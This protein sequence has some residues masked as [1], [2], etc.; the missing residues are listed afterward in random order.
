[1]WHPPIA[2]TP[3]E[4]KIAAR[5]RKTRKFFVCLRARRPELLD[6]DFQHMLAKSESPE[7]R[8]KTPVDVGLLA[9]AV[10]LQADCH[11]GDRDAGERTVMDTRWQRV[12]DCLG[13]EQPPFRQGTLCNLR[14]RLMA[15]N[16]DKTLLDRTVAWAE[17]TGG[18][19]ARQRRAALDSTP[20][21]GAG[22]VE[23]TLHVLGHALRKAVGLVGQAR[24]LATDMLLAEAGLTLVGHSSLKAALALDWGESGAKEKALRLVL[25]EVDRWK[26]WLEQHQSLSAPASPL[27]DVMDTIVQSVEQDTEPDPTGSPG[28]RRLRQHVAPDRRLSIEDQDRR[29]GRKSSATMFNGFKEPCV[30]ALDSKGT[31]EVVVCPANEPE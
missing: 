30:L 6:V 11:V 14:M 26:R 13:A 10:L 7:P 15:H 27:E 1:M 5:T 2:L 22:R 28:G 23:D 17:Q 31:R 12:R 20:R 3:E 9:L 29:H 4:Q 21:F 25:E 8:G 24:N 18:F 19:G 16:V